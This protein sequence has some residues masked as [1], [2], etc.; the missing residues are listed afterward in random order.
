MYDEL[1]WIHI[2]P[3]LEFCF[4]LDFTAVLHVCRAH[5]RW[6]SKNLDRFPY[7]FR[8]RVCIRFTI[9]DIRNKW[10]FIDLHLVLY[11]IVSDIDLDNEAP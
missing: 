10:T 11:Q 7:R 9:S 8:V 2:R 6:L 4:G 3:D 5:C 1:Q